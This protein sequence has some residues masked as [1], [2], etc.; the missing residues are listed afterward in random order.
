MPTTECQLIRRQDTH[1]SDATPSD[2]AGR[3]PMKARPEVR[4]PRYA[5]RREVEHYVQRI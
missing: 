2:Q 1:L 5:N 3:A 4:Y